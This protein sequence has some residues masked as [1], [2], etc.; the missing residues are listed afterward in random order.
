MHSSCARVRALNGRR[1]RPTN[2]VG[3]KLSELREGDTVTITGAKWHTGKAPYNV[4]TIR[5]AE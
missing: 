2:T 5:K 3:P 1:R 4:L